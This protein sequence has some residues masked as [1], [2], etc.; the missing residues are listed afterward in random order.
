MRK[1]EAVSFETLDMLT[2]KRLVELRGTIVSWLAVF[3][4]MRVEKLVK[5]R[6]KRGGRQEKK[7]R[8]Y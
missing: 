3:A 2:F 8:V 5:T 7:A 6:M 4:M 1:L